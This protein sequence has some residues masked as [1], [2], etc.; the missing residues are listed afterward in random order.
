MRRYRSQ[1]LALLLAL[2]LAF[3]AAACGGGDEEG[4]GDGATTGEAAA[5]DVSGNITALAVWTG[6]EGEAFRAVLDGFQQKYPD[7][8]VSY[9]SAKDPGQV[10][11][12]SV[13]GGNPPDVA[14]LPSPGLMADFANRGA[15]KP[16]DFARDTIEQNYSQGWI[17]LGTVEGKL[18][19]VF[20]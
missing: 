11:A 4:A 12:T 1:L 3:A 5:E 2:L 15:L 7:V 10:L 8:T 17:D 9:K 13:E 14:A 18:Y 20:F 6:A 16:I 19:G